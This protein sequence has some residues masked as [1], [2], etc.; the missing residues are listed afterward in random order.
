MADKSYNKIS[1]QMAGSLRRPKASGPIREGVGDCESRYKILFDNI[2]DGVAVYQPDNNG[3]DFIF[4]DM[5]KAGEK[6]SKVTKDAVIGQSVL[7]I[8]PGVKAFGLFDVFQKV[9]RAGHPEHH[10]VAEYK[11]DRIS[12]WVENYV[13]ILP[14]GEIVAIYSDKTEQKQLEE[15]L[16]RSNEKF[17][18][19]LDSIEDGYFEL[20]LAGNYTYVNDVTCRY[21]GFSREELL[22]M[23]NRKYMDPE[24]AKRI[25]VNR[26]F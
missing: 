25:Y 9:W 22:G 4:I 7:K 3:E 13:F 19:I 16:T 12:H 14:S 8:F 21:H 18:T 23:N 5:N 1:E 6:I 24:T 11:D 26:P 10:P 2:P 15:S 17:R 20:D